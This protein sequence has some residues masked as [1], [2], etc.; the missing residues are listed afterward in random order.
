MQLNSP[1]LEFAL[2]GGKPLSPSNFW[3][4][5]RYLVKAYCPC[6]LKCPPDD[7]FISEEQRAF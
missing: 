2:G 6:D 1:S 7:I 4:V 5:L 3:Y